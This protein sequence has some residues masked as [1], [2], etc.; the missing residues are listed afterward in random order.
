MTNLAQHPRIFFQEWNNSLEVLRDALEKNPQAQTLTLI[1]GDPVEY[2]PDLRRLEDSLNSEMVVAAEFLYL[3]KDALKL[4]PPLQSIRPIPRIS[5]SIS[6][7]KAGVL[8]N[9][10]EAIYAE[11]NGLGSPTDISAI[12]NR[13]GFS[14]VSVATDHREHISPKPQDLQAIARD[15]DGYMA[16]VENDWNSFEQTAA[17]RFSSLLQ[18]HE[19]TRVLVDASGLETKMNGTARNVLS[20]LE[21]LHKQLT[22][23]E[24]NWNVTVAIPSQAISHFGITFPN[25]KVVNSLSDISEV[26]DLGISIT[27]ITTMDRCLSLNELCL[28]WVVEHLDII[29]VRSLPFLSQQTQ[30]RRAINLYLNHADEV[31][32]I[33]SSSKQDA[34]QYFNLDKNVIAPQ[35]VIHLGAPDFK[36]IVA[37]ESSDP[38]YFLVLGNDHPHKQVDV[39]VDALIN[40]GFNVISLSSSRARGTGHTAKTPG[41]VSDMEMNRLIQGSKAVVFPSLYEGFGLPIAEAAANGKQVILWDTTV[42]HEVSK[43]LGTQKVNYF[44]SSAIELVDAAHS[45]IRSPQKVPSN[46]RTIDDFNK[47]TIASMARLISEPINVS[48]LNRRWEL[49]KLLS[50]VAGQAKTDAFSSIS[51]LHWRRRIAK[52]FTKIVR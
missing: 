33:S 42:S 12:L 8:K 21:Y 1:W 39:A 13:F 14:S 32:F 47:E 37:S 5:G 19:I 30:S 16:H 44:C 35:S 17:D 10:F 49:F 25:F 4:V 31:I 3:P 40:A 51:E 43:A 38:S 52:L 36:A 24:I 23:G 11:L 9:Y 46:M 29:A 7:F 48:R 6:V 41:S 20:F 22:I 45:I 27:P 50:A 2:V 26:F 28:R 15:W 18:T 34:A